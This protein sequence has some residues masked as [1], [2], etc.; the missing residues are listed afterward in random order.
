MNKNTYIKIFEFGEKNLDG[1][2][3]K[4]IIDEIPQLKDWEKMIIEENIKNAFYNKTH[5]GASGF[6]SK[7][8]FF[9]CMGAGGGDYGLNNLSKYILN[10][11][12]YFNYID[13]LELKEARETAKKAHTTSIWAIGIAIITLI[14]S[15][16]FSVIEI[17][18]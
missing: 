1:F 6:N 15:I 10:S 2:N 8:S 12:S 5:V 3:Y 7:E 11:E 17:C 4:K 14:T 16:I 13:Y 18:S 9:Y